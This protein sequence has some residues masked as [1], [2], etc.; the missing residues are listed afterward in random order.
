M[1]SEA[2]PHTEATA[3]HNL[4]ATIEPEIDWGELALADIIDVPAVQAL[5]E[6][7]QQLTGMLSAI[8]DTRG[9]VLISVGW[10]DICTKFHRCHP[11]TRKNCI[12]S[13]TVLA[14]A[15]EP[16]TF[17]AYHCKNGMWDISSPIVVS[18]QHL[19]NIYFGQFIYTDEVLDLEYFRQQARRYGFDESAYLDALQRVP[20]YDHETVKAVMAFHARMGTMI[21]DLGFKNLSLSRT[22]SERQR[23]E[24]ELKE[25][26]KRFQ[27]L[28]T[29]APL[30]Y[31]SLDFDGNFLEVNPKWLEILGYQKAE[32]IGKW[33]GDFLCPEY[34]EG[35]RQR[36]PLFKSQGYIHSEFEM[37]TK[38]GQRLTIAF[39][40]KIGYDVD[41]G[42]KQ[43][44]CI[45]QDITQQKAMEAQ[46]Y[47]EKELFRTTLFSIGDGVIATDTRGQ[48]LIMNKIAEQLTGWT[49]AEAAGKP[50]DEVFVIVNECTRE[51]C[52]NPVAKAL[53]AEAIIELA[54]HTLLISKDG[55]ERPIEDSAAPII[56]EQGNLTGVVLVFRDFTEKKKSQEE[57]K[58]ISFHDHLTGTYN[59]RFYEEELAR[60]D[61][62]RNW[63]LTIVMGDVNGLKLINDS[64]GH[65]TGDQLLIKTAAALTNGCRSDD[66]IARIGGDEFILL[67]PKTDAFEAAQLIKRIK[68]LLQK[69]SIEG[70]EISV[71]FG[72]ATKTSATEEIGEIF[73]QAED[74]MYHNKLYEGP[75]LKGRVIDNIVAALNSKSDREEIHS[76]QV[77]E[78]C[79]KMGAA[80]AMENYQIKELKA[81]GLLHDI[82]KIA[83]SDKILNKPDSLTEAEWLEMRNHAEIGYR[84]LCT[85]NDMIEIADYVLAHHE[86]WDG[87]GYPKGLKGLEIPLQSRI[88]AIADAYDA[89]IS[90]RSYKPVL[91]QEEAIVELRNHAG[92]QFD[93]ELVAVFIEQLSSSSN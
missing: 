48:V 32:V 64:F 61:T 71:S 39:D 4:T 43:T 53:A 7:F 82:G 73:K 3:P 87:Q 69:E 9:E 75:S 77:S 36:F 42:F 37:R 66:I 89:M 55:S 35:F 72:S 20:R 49:P 11:E 50:I 25:S 83:I 51:R 80:L 68:K 70:L 91:S 60:L 15:V 52:E 65:A 13:D 6:S 33:F 44:H 46:L 67:F 26:E 12:E 31:Q 81:F 45:L 92:T 90:A 41:G 38:D 28:F 29:R 14:Q 34:V 27:L 56:D 74:I 5:L 8:V 23:A 10:Q 17:Q 78:F 59:R 79:E 62:A 19:G 22:L 88:C 57:I 54:N 58:Y 63:P 1:N 40:G 24:A 16:G 2:G 47:N 84:I 76:R 18:G 21:S 85:N 86:R 30:G 93:P